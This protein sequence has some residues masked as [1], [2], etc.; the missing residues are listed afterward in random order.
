MDMNRI[1]LQCFHKQHGL[2]S[3]VLEYS[4]QPPW[5]VLL[6]LKSKIYESGICGD[7]FEGMVIIRQQLESGGWLVLCNASRLNAMPSAMS[8]EMG[9]AKMVY[10]H[11]TGAHPSRQD[12]VFIFA[13]IDSE[14]AATVREQMAYYQE[15]LVSIGL[16]QS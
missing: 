7:L 12:A 11:S 8:R 4:P 5:T 10:L 1:D 13:P 3:C 16:P 2:A 6:T 9:G 14:M 15:W